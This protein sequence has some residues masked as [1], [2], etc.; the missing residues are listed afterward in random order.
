M[1]TVDETSDEPIMLLTDEI[2]VD[3]ETG[4][5]ID[6]SLFQAEL[7]RLGE[8]G[9]KVVQLHINSIGGSVVDGMA[10]YH[11]MLNTKAKV[12]TYN[13]GLAGSIAAVIFQAGRTRYM[14][15][16]SILMYHGVQGGEGS[17]LDIMNDAVS[18]MIQRSGM[19]KAAVD[20]MMTKDTFINAEDALKLGLADKIQASTDQNKKRLPSPTNN[21]KAFKN[22][23]DLLINKKNMSLLKITN[24]LNLNAD[25]S[26]DSILSAILELQNKYDAS[27]LVNK[28]SKGEVDK[29]KN[30]MDDAEAK[31]KDLKDKFDKV[32]NE[33]DES[34]N[35]AKEEKAKNM[36]EGY[37]KIG[38]IKN[39]AKVL[40]KWANLAKVD[41][42]GAEEMI[43]DL[44]LSKDAPKIT[45]IDKPGDGKIGSTYNMAVSML[46]ITN[47]ANLKK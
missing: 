29:L 46:E 13:C 41:F 31:F 44:P 19:S 36:V 45:E 40:L 15:D 35:K 26:E 47:K 11:G 7:L 42:A 4:K 22:S 27:L 23:C 1:Y 38:R 8:M 17:S 14:A 34:E 33:L 21:L 10:I 20:Q 2:G 32:K 16:Y 3:P 9:K 24:K 30:D 18:K 5:G 43:K 6:G 12:D 28:A 25:A 37:A 39:D